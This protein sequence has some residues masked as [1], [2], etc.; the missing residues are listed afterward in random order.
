MFVGLDFHEIQF[1]GRITM[2]KKDADIAYCLK[3]HAPF[4]WVHYVF[5]GAFFAAFSFDQA[6]V[7][8]NGITMN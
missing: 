7:N 2:P 8:G 4:I 5:W 6:G 1:S 3:I